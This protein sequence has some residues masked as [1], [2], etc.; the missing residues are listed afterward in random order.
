MDYFDECLYCKNKGKCTKSNKDGECKD[1]SV[2]LDY[3]TEPIH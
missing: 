1:Y 2:M 3:N